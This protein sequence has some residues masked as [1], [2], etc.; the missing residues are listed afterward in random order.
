MTNNEIA[1]WEK[2]NAHLE[3]RVTSNVYKIY[4]NRLALQIV[5]DLGVIVLCPDS[6]AKALIEKSLGT[7]FEEAIK[8]LTKSSYWVRFQISKPEIAPVPKKKKTVQ[9]VDLFNQEDFEKS[10]KETVQEKAL[11]V[12]GISPRY[13]FENYLMGANNQ[14]AFAVAK[15]VAERPGETYNPLF[16][17]SGVGLGKTHLMQAIGNQILKNKPALKVVYT[18]AETFT[19]ELIEAIQSSKGRGQYTVNK[20][21]T[22]FRNAD[23]LLVDDVQFI[24]GRETTQQE[25]FHTFNALYLAQKQI[26]MTSDRPPRDFVN[27][28]ERVKSRFGSGMI[29]DIQPPDYD[30]RVAI[31]RQKRDDSGDPVSNEVIDL[32]AK[33]IV[34]NVRELLGAYLQLLTKYITEGQ[35]ITPTLVMSEL[36]QRGDLQKKKPVNIN[37]ILKAVCT[38][39]SVKAEDVKGQRRTKDIVLPRQTTM[40][41]IYDLTK[42]PYMTIGEFLGG[43]D[44]STIIHGVRKIEEDLKS[45]AKTKSDIANIIQNV[46][47]A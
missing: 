42:T 23:V 31:L 24:V 35:D 41:L 11:E 6:Y 7:I 28:E 12:S 8:E 3:P 2:L 46:H 18:A 43:R 39:Y 44:H 32:L 29:V 22:K 13:K 19:N 10:S 20:F 1:L 26:V 25:F 16:I 40:Y 45:D 15:A 27:L 37:Q 9:S 14:L 33:N 4:S 30:M 5:D 21:R 17:Y 38:Y 36:G 47:N 34:T